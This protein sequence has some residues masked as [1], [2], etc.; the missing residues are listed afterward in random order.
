MLVAN[1]K[2]PEPFVGGGVPS[3]QEDHTGLTE[4]TYQYIQGHRQEIVIW[5]VV[6]LIGVI[7]WDGFI[8]TEYI[9]WDQ[10]CFRAPSARTV[11]DIQKVQYRIT[12]YSVASK[13]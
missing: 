1:Q 13:R 4:A 2:S 8:C 11:L 3:I 7:V 6:V 5:I 12:R 10:A 9:F